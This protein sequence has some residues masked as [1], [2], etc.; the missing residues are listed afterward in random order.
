ME[1]VIRMKGASGGI[2]KAS[3]KHNAT[4]LNASKEW[5]LTNSDPQ[6]FVIPFTLPLSIPY[7]GT[8]TINFGRASTYG[9]L[10][11]DVQLRTT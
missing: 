8:L 10:L 2:F 5:T 4:G 3:V 7:N 1:L 9:G 11:Y 6:E